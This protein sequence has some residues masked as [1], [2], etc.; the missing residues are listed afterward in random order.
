MNAEI[1]IKNG[2]ASEIVYKK[3]T[4]KPLP[5]RQQRDFEEDVNKNTESNIEVW[6]N[7]HILNK[8]IRKNKK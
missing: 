3:I 5:A 7:Y 8:P 1:H 6:I 4:K 2:T